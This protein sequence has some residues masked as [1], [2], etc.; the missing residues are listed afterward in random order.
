[1]ENG[2]E[3][4]EK[5]SA[6]KFFG[7][8]GDIKKARYLFTKDCRHHNPYTEPGMDALLEAI[9]RVQGDKSMQGNKNATF[10][11][12]SVIAEGDMVAVYTTLQSEDKK[13]GLR[14]VHLF[15]FGS[16]GK[17]EEYWD[18]TQSTPANAPYP[19]NMF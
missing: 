3:K 4:Q 1:M 17:I 19:E 10:K 7:A 13:S 9:V 18:V 8:L 15:R 2:I 14:Q 6:L 12:R 11:V 16:S 5:E